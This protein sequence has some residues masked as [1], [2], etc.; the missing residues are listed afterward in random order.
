M[1]YFYP[2]DELESV[3]DN[4]TV[5]SHQFDEIMIWLNINVYKPVNGM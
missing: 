5:T 3:I 4:N 1:N 2:V